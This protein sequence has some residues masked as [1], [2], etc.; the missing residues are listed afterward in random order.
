M[1]ERLAVQTVEGEAPAKVHIATRSGRTWAVVRTLSS[2]LP[3][4][5][6]TAVGNTFGMALATHGSYVAI[7]ES[8][9]NRAWIVDLD[10]ER[11]PCELVVA[12][13]GT[14]VKE[15]G[16]AWVGGSLFVHVGDRVTRFE[17]DDC[18]R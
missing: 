5:P 14:R 18:F 7:G 9:R 10:R 17:V 2:P 4:R 15:L 3:P 6:V 13:D 16:L 8:G 1:R 11:L 12:P